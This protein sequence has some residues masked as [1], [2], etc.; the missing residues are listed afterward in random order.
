MIYTVLKI[1]VKEWG[2]SSEER[3][4]TTKSTA[5]GEELEPAEDLLGTLYKHSGA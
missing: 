3:E 4:Q 5:L 1:T 2:K